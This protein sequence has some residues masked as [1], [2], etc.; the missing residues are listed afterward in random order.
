MSKSAPPIDSVTADVGAC[1]G[2]M[3]NCSAPPALAYALRLWRVELRENSRAGASQ[4]TC[5]ASCWMLTCTVRTRSAGLS[6]GHSS[7][8]LRSEEHTSELQS[9]MRTS[10]A[11]FCLQITTS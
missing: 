3:S 7:V 11:V 9:L 6:R 10:Y 8:A 4:V 2:T 5:L 1:T